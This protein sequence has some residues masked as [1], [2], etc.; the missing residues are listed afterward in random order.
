MKQ[1]IHNERGAIFLVEL[2]FIVVVL[3]VTGL[4]IY[5][6]HQRTNSRQSIVK[7]PREPSQIQNE[8]KTY[9]DSKIGLSFQYPSGL[10]PNGSSANGRKL[11]VNISKIDDLD[12]PPARVATPELAREEMIALAKGDVSQGPS[13]EAPGKLLKLT[14]G[15]IGA[16]YMILREL[17]A[18]DVQFTL[19]A[20][21]YRNDYQI[22]ITLID[23]D[24]A[25]LE[26]R[27]P[28]YFV[29]DPNCNIDPGTAYKSWRSAEQ[30]AKD[31]AAGNTDSESQKWYTM[32]EQ[33]VS[34][35][36]FK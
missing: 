18:C 7:T 28:K 17:D 2:I 24:V 8:S 16:T 4:A 11:E 3:A 36:S 27:N 22:I 19:Q 35:L 33:L 14:D 32:F 31:I 5:Q 34:S 23:Q 15:A 1:E 21:I 9:T 12:G 30:F 26:T 10:V 25:T 20:R 29:V 6:V 13:S